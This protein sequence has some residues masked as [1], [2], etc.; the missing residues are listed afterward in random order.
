MVFKKA[1]KSSDIDE[2]AKCALDDKFPVIATYKKINSF[3]DSLDRI[4]EYL[5][6]VIHSGI[7]PLVTTAKEILER[8]ENYE[9]TLM[10]RLIVLKNGS[11]YLLELVESN[12]LATIQRI[13][14]TSRPAAR[15]SW[16][17]VK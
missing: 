7:Q 3:Y 10:E 8:L 4:K 17:Y 9:N 11:P 5:L 14:S 6:K 16:R 15:V 13:A 12:K 2:M 1:L